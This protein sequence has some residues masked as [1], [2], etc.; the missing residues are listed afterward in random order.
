LTA[1]GAFVRPLQIF[2]W[3]VPS[4]ITFQVGYVRSGSNIVNIGLYSYMP[5]NQHIYWNCCSQRNY[6]YHRKSGSWPCGRY[7]PR[8]NWL[9]WHHATTVWSC[10][11]FFLSFRYF[12][13]HW[14]A[15]LFPGNPFCCWR[16]SLHWRCSRLANVSI[17]SDSIL[18]TLSSCS[19]TFLASCLLACWWHCV[20][21]K[22]ALV[23]QP[24]C[25]IFLQKYLAFSL[26]DCSLRVKVVHKP[27]VRW[28]F[29]RYYYY[30]M[31]ADNID[32]L[33][34]WPLESR[35]CS[36]S[37]EWILNMINFWL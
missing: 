30:D 28:V 26:V 21:L 5:I 19:V 4:Y 36:W 33:R 1:I 10:R 27:C 8:R 15:S 23:F 16:I 12:T 32:S 11:Q 13:R 17:S 29:T 18:F 25:A 6:H 7:T 2:T 14:F 31:D 22:R 24:R 3:I 35:A 20:L 34:L 9:T 37:R